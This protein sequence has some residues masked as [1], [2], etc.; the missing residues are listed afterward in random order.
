MRTPA[1][2]SCVA[3]SPGRRRLGR[4][5]LGLAQLGNGDGQRHDVGDEH[6]GDQRGFAGDRAG[7][8]H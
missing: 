1:A 2:R 4:V 8:R 7:Q 6:D 5:P 3:A